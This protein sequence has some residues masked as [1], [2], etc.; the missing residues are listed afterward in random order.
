MDKVEQGV[1]D[2]LTAADYILERCDMDG[3]MSCHEVIRIMN[4]IRT[5]LRLPKTKIESEEET[6]KSKT[7]F[8]PFVKVGEIISK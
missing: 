7:V 6:F 2:K 1:L 8:T 5:I 4:I 3:N